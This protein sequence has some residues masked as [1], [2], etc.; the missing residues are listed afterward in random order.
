[1]NILNKLIVAA[2]LL[3]LAACGGSKNETRPVPAVTHPPLIAGNGE[4][5]ITTT[6]TPVNTSGNV[7]NGASADFNMDGFADLII[8]TNFNAPNSPAATP[9]RMYLFNK[10]TNSYEYTALTIDGKIADPQ[11]FFGMYIATY[12][13]N[14]DGI[15]D[16]IPIDAS[17]FIAPGKTLFNGAPQFAYVSTGIGKYTKLD[18]GFN[19]IT[20][21]GWGI[22]KSTGGKFAIMM[23]AP[24]NNYS[25][26]AIGTGISTYNPATG[27]FEPAFITRANPYYTNVPATPDINYFYQT[28][29]DVN[30]DGNDDIIAFSSSKTGTSSIYLND[31][32]NNFT[33]SKTFAT[34]LVPNNNVEEVAV[35]DFNGDGK[36]DIAVLSVDRTTN[37]LHKSVRILINTNGTYVDKTLRW[38]GKKFQ[39]VNISYGYIDVF[40]FNDDNTQD[41]AFTYQTATGK[42]VI[43]LFS[44]NSTSFDMYTVDTDAIGPRIIPISK[45]SFIYA[46]QWSTKFNTTAT[47]TVNR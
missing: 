1:M 33:F 43:T 15:T 22:I 13:I 20:A 36:D 32:S 14:K 31:G 18:L 42:N 23:H 5:S 30:G 29:A 12:D 44:S 17:E 11:A 3:I 37:T 45:N 27:Q 38:L 39:D 40:N 7:G 34:G 46:T 35:A 2:V 19:K 47:V 6:K 8:A 41:I 9:I 4:F 16:F 21:H 25:K 26:T 24:W 10:A 28:T